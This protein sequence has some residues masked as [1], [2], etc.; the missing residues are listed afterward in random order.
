MISVLKTAQLVVLIRIIQSGSI[1]FKWGT[2]K[3][4]SYSENVFFVEGDFSDLLSFLFSLCTF[5]DRQ[6][7]IVMLF[8]Q[9]V[10]LQLLLEFAWWDN[11]NCFFLVL[12]GQKSLDLNFLFVLIDQLV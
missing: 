4:A 9:A 10:L 2:T 7:I 6:Q 12:G 5:Y 11:N 1:A 3:G 8:L